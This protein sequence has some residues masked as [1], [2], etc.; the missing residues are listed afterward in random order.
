MPRA[1]EVG[2]PILRN[3][4]GRGVEAGVGRG[5][6]FGRGEGPGLDAPDGR[7][8]MAIWYDF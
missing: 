8:V 5:G 1:T 2:A 6:C 7:M 3:T 4:A